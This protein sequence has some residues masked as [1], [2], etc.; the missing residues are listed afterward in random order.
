MVAWDFQKVMTK[1]LN[2]SNEEGGRYHHH[3]NMRLEGTFLK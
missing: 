3:L 2:D 1:M